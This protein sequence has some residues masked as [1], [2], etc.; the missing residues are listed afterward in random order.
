[1]YRSSEN[2]Q[3]CISINSSSNNSSVRFSNRL[4]EVVVAKV[5][6][7]LLDIEVVVVLI[8]VVVVAEVA[9]VSI[10]VV[11][12]ISRISRSSNRFVNVVLV[13]KIC[14]KNSIS[15]RRGGV[16]EVVVVTDVKK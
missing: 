6:M 14:H 5:A 11:R 7:A 12:S 13:V 3:S 16:S 8:V 1:M 9:V 10:A 2:S 4:V 15:R